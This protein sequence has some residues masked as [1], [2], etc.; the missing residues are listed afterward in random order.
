MFINK[1]ILLFHGDDKD[2]QFQRLALADLG[3]RFAGVRTAVDDCLAGSAVRDFIRS[4]SAHEPV[5]GIVGAGCS[6]VRYAMEDDK[7]NL[8]RLTKKKMNNA[9]DIDEAMKNMHSII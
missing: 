5:I 4:L 8:D 9:E 2:S 6:Q 3:L 7:I 1:T